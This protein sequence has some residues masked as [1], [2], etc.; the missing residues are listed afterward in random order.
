M[1]DYTTIFAPKLIMFFNLQLSGTRSKTTHCTVYACLRVKGLTQFLIK[2][3]F[4]KGARGCKQ[5]IKKYTHG[6]FD[7]DRMEILERSG[8]YVKYTFSV[9]AQ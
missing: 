5:F 8:S 3:N 1:G 2:M 9:Q 6:E 7:Q 4:S